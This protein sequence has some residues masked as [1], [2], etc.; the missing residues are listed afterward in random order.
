M[1]PEETQPLVE[2]GPLAPSERNRLDAVQQE[3]A[4][5]E[6]GPSGDES[7]PSTVRMTAKGGR[8]L[9][10]VTVEAPSRAAAFRA[11]EDALASAPRTAKRP[12]RSK[13]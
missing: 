13:K 6:Y 9:D 8:L 3:G 7:A 10:P 12:R 4:E 2:T 11:L 5:V 1:T